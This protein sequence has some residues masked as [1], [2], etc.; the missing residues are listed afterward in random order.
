MRP[1]LSALIAIAL[2]AGAPSATAGSGPEPVLD[3]KIGQMIMVGFR[4]LAV[5]DG[6]P[7]ARDIRERHVGGVILFDYD[8]P[9]RTWGRNIESPGQLKTLTASL[10]KRAALP[11]FVAV[12]QEG[13]RIVRLKE[14]AGFPPSL[15]QKRLGATGDPGKTAR[16]A[17]TT[18]KTLAELG[19]N[20]NFAPVVDL[21]LNPSNPVIGKLERSFSRNPG[22]VTRHALV[23]IDAHRRYGI[24]TA[25]KHFPGHGSA[26]GDTHE[27]FVDV[28][29][30][31][32][33]AELEPFQD[34]IRRGKADMIMTAHIF[35]GKLDP[36]WP[37]TLSRKTLTDL[38]RRDMGFSGVV[39]S[40][41]LQMKAIASRYSLETAIRKALLAGVDIL[42]FANNSVYEEDIAAR[43]AGV[44]RG[45]V[46]KG[47]IPRER[48]DESW[49]RILKLKERL[50]FH[51]SRP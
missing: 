11:L 42:L 25:P 43:A 51:P 17:E 40:D 28:T 34:L 48:I 4:G 1:L 38:L 3:V 19:I 21:D 32:S 14:K 26:A 22:T 39:I 8:V 15:S 7:V 47:D 5:A 33:A 24:L 27:G 35:N 31:W 41:D 29:G 18:A 46:E 16:Q 49:R 37:S 10:K 50:S 20:L 44:I 30:R 6:D 13:G 36:E 23:V 12:D 9:T 2:L 45:L